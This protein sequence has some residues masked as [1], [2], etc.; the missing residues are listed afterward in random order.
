MLYSCFLKEEEEKK[1]NAE[2]SFI[3]TNPVMPASW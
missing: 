2:N 1:K 3:K